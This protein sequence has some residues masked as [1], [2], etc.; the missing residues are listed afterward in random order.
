MPAAICQRR[1]FSGCPLE[2]I[3][4]FALGMPE[5]GG[6]QIAGDPCSKL[7]GPATQCRS[8]PVSGTCLPKT[9]IFQVSAADYGRFRSR[10]GQFLSP[11]TDCQFAKA[12]QWPPLFALDH[13]K[14]PRTASSSVA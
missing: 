4:H 13:P 6:A 7:A 9:G 1:E 8:N 2:T 5:M 10:T 11:A 3:G 12:R 14:L